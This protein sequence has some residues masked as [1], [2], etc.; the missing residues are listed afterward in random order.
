M[1]T[2]INQSN[3]RRFVFMLIG[4]F[5]LGVGIGL[6]KLSLM[7][8]DPNTAF[9]IAAAAK[10]GVDF[11]VLNLFVNSA[12]FILEYIFGR[13]LIGI[14]TFI[15]WVMVGTVA[16]A[17]DHLGRYL[18]LAPEHF[19]S[20]LLVMVLGILILTLSCAIYQTADMGIAPYDSLSIILSRR[21]GRSYFWCRAFTD[22]VG[23]LLALLLGGLL[24][25]GTLMCALGLSPF[26]SFFTKY[27]AEPLLGPAI[28]SVKKEGV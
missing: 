26:I 4:V 21:S 13:S 20:K 14:G 3:V 24:G 10:L 28:T 18:H 25:V 5:F 1:P 12:Y 27:V 19:A 23:A 7:G 11:A 6:F 17:C 2:H 15:N 16:S 9:V 22:C 8:N